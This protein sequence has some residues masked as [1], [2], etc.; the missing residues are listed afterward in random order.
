MFYEEHFVYFIKF[1][2]S[3]LGV[4]SL[5]GLLYV[6]GEEDES[7]IYSAEIFNPKTNTW[8]MLT[9]NMDICRTI[10]GGAV[11]VNKYPFFKS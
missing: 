1:I 6:V 7:N 10:F 8:T 2:Y 3:Y 11:V 9:S 5:N 4:V